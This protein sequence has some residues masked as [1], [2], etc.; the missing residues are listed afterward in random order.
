MTNFVGFAASP[1]PDPKRRTKKLEFTVELE[2]SLKQVLQLMST[3]DGF[4]QIIDPVV[5]FDFRPGGRN[6]FSHEDLEYRGTFS[7]IAIPRAIV[8]NTERH[9]EL[10]FRF[11]ELKDRSRVSLSAQKALLPEEEQGWIE[12]CNSIE[13][14][15]RSTFG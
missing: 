11:K 2:T 13:Q 6:T 3:A 10:N 12:A 5:R 15:L 14:K 4:A 7:Q 1:K 8:L 9:G